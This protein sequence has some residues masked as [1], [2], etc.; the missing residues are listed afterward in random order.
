MNVP[1]QRSASAGIRLACQL[2]TS[3]DLTLDVSENIHK[4]KWREFEF[5]PRSHSL[6]A[7]GVNH[8]FGVAVDIGTTQIKAMLCNRVTGQEY[9]SVYGPNPQNV[10]GADVITRL[11]KS[12]DSE[13]FL[14]T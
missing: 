10:Y 6:R 14:T 8:S 7:Q 12:T 4:S 5:T 2:Q 11:V 13:C 3:E 9:L 1:R